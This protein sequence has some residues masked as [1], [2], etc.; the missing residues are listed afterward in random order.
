MATKMKST[1]NVLQLNCDK[2]KAATLHLEKLSNEIDAKIIC[3][4]EPYCNLHKDGNLS[5]FSPLEFVNYRCHYVNS[6]ERPMVAIYTRSNIKC[7][8]VS[9]IS[10]EHCI[11]IEIQ[12]SKCKFYVASIYSHP[13]DLTPLSRFQ[14][15]QGL[16]TENIKNL[17]ICTD[18]NAKSTMWG[19]RCTDLKGSELESM[20]LQ[21]QINVVNDEDSPPT[22]QNNTG[23]KSWIDLTCAGNRII[24]HLHSWE[25][26]NIASL[27]FHKILSF[28]IEIDLPHSHPNINLRRTNWDMVN[29]II[30]QD[31][32]SQDT[33]KNVDDITDTI[34]LEKVCRQF[35][36]CLENAVKESTPKPKDKSHNKPVPW[37][38]KDLDYMRKENNRLRRKM[39]RSQNE[40]V[41]YNEEYKKH[42]K[43]FKAM[44][45]KG[46]WENFKKFASEIKD[47]YDFIKKTIKKTTRRSIPSLRKHDDSY[48]KDDGET[49]SYLLSMMFPDDDDSTDLPIHTLVRHYVSRE[50]M[51]NDESELPE[52][53]TSNEL[54]II[55]EMDGFKAAPDIL[56]GVCY[57]RTFDSIKDFVLK[58]FNKCLQLMFYPSYWKCAVV[59]VVLKP[60]KSDISHYKSYRPISLLPIIGK[61]FSK[62]I[63]KRLQW[64][65][66]ES[67]WI[68]DRQFGFQHGKSC[69]M[70]L[71]K[72]T[73]IVENCFATKK[74]VLVIALDISGAFD[75]TWHPSIL[76]NL[77]KTNCNHQYLKLIAN[78][79]SNRKVTINI[80]DSKA[81]KSLSRSCPQGEIFSPLLWN[82]D[83][84][85]LFQLE[86]SDEISAFA[87][88]S[89]L[90]FIGD[91][92]SK[93]EENANRALQR[94]SEWGRIKK[95]KFNKSKTEAV[96]FSRRY[97]IPFIRLE[98]EGEQIK[99]N[100]SMKSL[101]IHLDSK[102]LYHEHI[103]TQC[104]KTKR[105]IFAIIKYCSTT[106][107]LNRSILKTLW[108]VCIEPILLY[109]APIWLT[110]IQKQW[111][112]RELKSVQRLMAL[113][114]I[115][116]FKTVPYETCITLSGLLPIL[117]KIKSRA[118]VFF[119]KH[120]E[121]LQRNCESTRYAVDMM[122]ESNVDAASYEKDV[123]LN[124][125]MYPPTR[126]ELSVIIKEDIE[127]NDGFVNIYTDGS[128]TSNGTGAAA[129]IINKETTI[130]TMGR[131]RKENTIYQAEALGII[132]ALSA[133]L[134]LD[135][136]EQ[137]INIYSDSMSVLVCLS[138]SDERNELI[139]RIKSIY[140]SLIRR[141]KTISFYWCRGH[142]GIEGNELADQYAKRATTAQIP[143][144]LLSLPI[145]HLKRTLKEDTISNWEK[146]W[147]TNNSTCATFLPFP[148][149]VKSKH[150]D[151]HQLTQIL[152]GHNKLNFYLQ[153][154][155]I[156][157][158]S[159]CD[160]GEA[161][162]DTDHFLFYCSNYRVLRQNMRD[163]CELLMLK[164]P[165]ERSE[166][167]ANPLLLKELKIF[168]KRSKRLDYD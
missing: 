28:V 161:I 16:A 121:C 168:L 2:G 119:A 99:V 15:F 148:M 64:L 97:I 89:N 42:S 32:I 22:F 8:I 27:S 151:C 66:N 124:H 103:S 164:W 122:S 21:Y 129:V 10:D 88:D 93:I 112:Q 90:F 108:N 106:W 50:L 18:A 52:P 61:W 139:N 71:S 43:L 1:L 137:A 79:L 150:T 23:G 114:I 145:S 65:S 48:T 128:K 29:E 162:E 36:E 55:F 102:L 37:W 147:Q 132:M 115:K 35:T 104:G 130:V 125:Q 84:N 54:K 123:P 136:N 140:T 34:A 73:S 135:V 91:S 155:G 154:Y 51:A 31:L 98:M 53:I 152:T 30:Q 141:G 44:I 82:I 86:L 127:I 80:N 77:M 75:G 7:R 5:K 118:M 46:K 149:K 138:S 110:S 96:L 70:A 95:M 116:A 94:I 163:V 144:V 146:S 107:G 85:D 39:Q 47:P 13:T 158:S 17:V 45:K 60:N 120:P 78:F 62:I 101:G 41:Q 159:I 33:F 56:L 76:Y 165:P 12:S 134:H 109:G 111:C 40:N 133:L 72:F 81:S 105:L 19:N 26:L 57:Q 14:I 59:S 9:N 157:E 6:T 67:D 63:Y 166:L 153:S 100:T 38:N 68:D 156:R 20:F 49:A 3:A 83:F 143:T 58:I 167:F 69:E 4:Q 74:F 117:D 87:D 142:T 24:E 113:R 25:V 11:C 160:C 131:L 126:I 92:A